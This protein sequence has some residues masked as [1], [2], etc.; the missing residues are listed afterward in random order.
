VYDTS[1]APGQRL[2]SATLARGGAIRPDGR[3][4]LVLNDFMATN[5]DYGPPSS[6]SVEPLRISDLEALIR[7]AGSRPQP[8]QPDTTARIRLTTDAGAAP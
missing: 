1:R 6:L 8:I 7:W 4:T 3:Y 5:A 2:V